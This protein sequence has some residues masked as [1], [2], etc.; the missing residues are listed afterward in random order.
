MQPDGVLR[1]QAD[2]CAHADL[3]VVEVQEVRAVRP[4]DR[5][6]REHRDDDRPDEEVAQLVAAVVANQVHRERQQHDGGRQPRADR[7][8]EHDAGE[9]GP[10]RDQEVVGAEDERQRP[11]VVHRVHAVD[12]EQRLEREPDHEQG[13]VRHLQLAHDVREE[14][15][16]QQRDGDRQRVRRD[17]AALDDERVRQ[18]RHGV[19]GQPRRIE[20]VVVPQPVAGEGDAPR[21]GLRAV[22]VVD[23]RRPAGH[24]RQRQHEER[25]RPREIEFEDPADRSDAAA[26]SFGAPTAG[27]PASIEASTPVIHPHPASPSRE[28]RP[29]VL[30]YALTYT[31]A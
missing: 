10:F 12:P 13:R 23:E 27:T 4:D 1:E 21:V 31:H 8:A 15:E 7:Q 20:L 9:D 17:P 11:G 14:P 24:E 18:L 3:R 25:Q 16:A 30:G 29:T 6:E 19:A 22:A 2:H 5:Q 26:S 28:I